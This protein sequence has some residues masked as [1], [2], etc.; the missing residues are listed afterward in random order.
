MAAPKSP[1][2]Q[3]VLPLTDPNHVQEVF[4]NN[5][6]GIR[7]SGDIAHITLSVIR[8]PHYPVGGPDEN[9]VTVRITTPVA[10]LNAIIASLQQLALAQAQAQPIPGKPN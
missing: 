6:A 5:V 4:A 7:I 9:V 10:T 3:A 8:P 2:Q 1:S